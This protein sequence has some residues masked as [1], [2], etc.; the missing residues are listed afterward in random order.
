VVERCSV[1]IPQVY[2]HAAQPF[3]IVCSGSSLALQQHSFT[4]CWAIGL[5]TLRAPT[6]YKVSGHLRTIPLGDKTV[7]DKP[8]GDRHLGTKTFGDSQL[9]TNTFGDKTYGDTWGHD[10][11]G[12]SQLRFILPWLGRATRSGAL[13]RG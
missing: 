2:A 5:C 8:F 4:F 6:H 7:A 9:G 3:A 11:C 12:Q 10:I 1:I 13:Y